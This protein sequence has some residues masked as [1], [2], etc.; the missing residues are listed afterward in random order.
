MLAKK[1]GVS[2]LWIE[3]DSLNIIN[4]LLLKCLPSWSIS[5]FIND[6]IS[7]ITSFV[8]IIILYVFREA[9]L[10]ANGLANLGVV[11]QNN[12]D[13]FESLPLNLKI[14]SNNDQVSCY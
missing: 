5:H 7:I 1:L 10:L 13:E 2:K 4:C 8:E 12:W 9:I 6:S 11:A 14:I 3:G